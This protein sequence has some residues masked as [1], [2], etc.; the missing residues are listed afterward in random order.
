MA[1]CVGRW[2]AARMSTATARLGGDGVGVDG[3]GFGEFG[4]FVDDDHERRPV[5]GRFPDACTGF[6]RLDGSLFQFALLSVADERRR[7][8]SWADGCDHDWHYLRASEDAN[9]ATT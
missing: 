6:A 1:S 7:A 3:G 9:P 5:F 2:V 8:H 4:V